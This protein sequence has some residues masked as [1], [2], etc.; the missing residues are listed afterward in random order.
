MLIDGFTVVAQ[1]INFLILL[2]LLH[3]FLYQPILKTL[4]KRQAQLAARWQA[5]R[6][7]QDKAAA[8]LETHRQAQRELEAHRQAQLA[9]AAAAIAA[10]RQAQLQQVRQEVEQT[11]RAGLDAVAAEQQRWWVGWQR[12]LGQ[13]AIAVARQ[14]LQDLANQDLEAQIIQVF[15]QRL[16]ALDTDTHQAIATAFRRQ[17]RP[18]TLETSWPLSA[19]HQAQLRQ[20]LTAAHLLGDQPLE[21]AT[22][23]DLIGGIRLHNDAYDLTWSL[24]DHL[25]TLEGTLQAAMVEAG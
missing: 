24:A 17:Q 14:V 7:E 16:L 10:T 9:A 22:S 1:I 8:A 15:Q 6:L 18:I 11:R 21:F 23:A 20:T 4:G 13:Q 2:G 3:H 25:Q 19:A 12:H 5:A